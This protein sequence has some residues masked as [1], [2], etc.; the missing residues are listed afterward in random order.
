MTRWRT[1][2]IGA[3]L[4]AFAC[5]ASR[6][7]VFGWGDTQAFSDYGGSDWH[8]DVAHQ[9]FMTQPQAWLTQSYQGVF[10]NVFLYLAAKLDALEDVDGRTVLDN[11][12][13]AW[14]Q[15]CCMAT[16]DSYAI[17][18][19]TFGGAGGAFNTGLYCD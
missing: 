14:S 18:V 17:P 2:V 11:T 8:Q 7:G 19:V 15:E 6:I 12:L 5:E 1:L 13:M 10:E 4:A 3:C 16:H 9:W